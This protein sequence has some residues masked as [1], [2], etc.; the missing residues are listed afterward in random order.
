MNVNNKRASS[1]KEIW[2]IQNRFV[3]FDFL[4]ILA[5][6]LIFKVARPS[7][8]FWDGQGPFLEKSKIEVGDYTLRC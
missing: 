2:K 7:R 1:E 3:S 6:K 4:E 8:N 5:E